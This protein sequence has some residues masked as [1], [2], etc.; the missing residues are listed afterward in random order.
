MDLGIETEPTVK[1]N[2]GEIMHVISA[3]LTQ[4]MNQFL[5]NS[6]NKVTV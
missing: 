1:G 6:P 4:E 2:L 5:K 3:V